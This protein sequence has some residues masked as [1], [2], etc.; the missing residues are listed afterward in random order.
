MMATQEKID[1]FRTHQDEYAA[2]KSPILVNIREGIY[3]T[4]EGHGAPG[5]AEFTAKVGALY[6]V[7]YTI[8]MTRRFAGEQ[9]YVIG[10]LE[11]QWWGEQEGVRFEQLPREKWNWRLLIRTPGFVGKHELK[12]A[13]S[14]LL[15]KGKQ[16]EVAQVRLEKMAEGMCIQMLH[17]GPYE[18][19]SETIG[20]M[21]EFA[22]R[23][24]LVP[25][26]K[27]HEIYLSDPRRVPPER[28]K[29]ILRMPVVCRD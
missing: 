4:I 20:E 2:P 23:E 3:L 7:A 26:G 1:L 29:T 21:K 24:G 11:A 10:K 22:Y 25:V 13:V 5:G 16:R 28:L 17:V 15:D 14:A 12:Q 27:H 18:R 8:K 6:G 19:E 9:D